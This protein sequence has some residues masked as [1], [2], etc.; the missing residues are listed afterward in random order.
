MNVPDFEPE[1]RAGNDEFE[2]E[3]HFLGFSYDPRYRS[4]CEC[5]CGFTSLGHV[6]Y[7]EIVY[8]HG[9]GEDVVTLFGRFEY[10]RMFLDDG[11][12][13]YEGSHSKCK[14]YTIFIHRRN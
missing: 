13:I 10:R 6:A 8:V 3:K 5:G 11:L 9:V 7:L 1:R 14:N 4:K 12:Q 2:L